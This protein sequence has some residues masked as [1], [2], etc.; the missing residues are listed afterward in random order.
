M[1]KDIFVNRFMSEKQ[2]NLYWITSALFAGAFLGL[3]NFVYASNFSK[4]GLKGLGV[5]GPGTLTVFTFVKILREYLYYYKH[6]KW[7][8]A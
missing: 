5:L 3:G 4:F 2:S 7:F 8:K 6:H 1:I